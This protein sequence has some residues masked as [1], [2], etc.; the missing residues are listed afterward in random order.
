MTINNL[1][2][3]LASINVKQAKEELTIQD[4]R[5]VLNEFNYYIMLENLELDKLEI[6]QEI[7][8]KIHK[9]IIELKKLELE[10]KAKK[11]I[12][13][14]EFYQELAKIFDIIKIKRE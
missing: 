1:K 11:K 8:L 10:Y 2:D 4:I 7:E 6:I 13:K 9:N 14:Q 5:K 3:S 12:F